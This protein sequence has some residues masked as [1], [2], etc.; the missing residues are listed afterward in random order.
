M[1][2]FI[3]SILKISE[4]ILKFIIAIITMVVLFNFIQLN[5]MKKEYP[6]F[7]GYTI[8]EVISDSMSP[9]IN[10]GDVIIVKINDPDIKKQDIITYKDKRDF[11]THRV[12]EV[13]EK[14]YI[15]KGD[16]N[17]TGDRPIFKENVVGKVIKIL[18]RFGVWKN[19]LTTPKILI[20]FLITIILLSSSFKDW[21]K[22][23]YHSLKDFKITN[24]SIIEK[25]G[26]KNDK[27]KK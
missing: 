8:F 6:N 11:I 24:D 22:A 2:T 13:Q 14:A 25:V 18:P 3:N 27:K 23:K 17:N 26:V 21:T 4:Y 7:F 1:K 16:Y 20:I 12:V 5:I 19:I 9:K 10:K 15:T